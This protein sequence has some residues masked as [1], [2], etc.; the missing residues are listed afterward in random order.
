MKKLYSFVLGLLTMAAISCIA[1]ANVQADSSLSEL[2]VKERNSAG[3]TNDLVLSPSFSPEITEYNVTAMS[4]TIALDIVASVTEAG[5][6][7]DTDWLALDPGDNTSYIYVTDAE[8]NKT[9]YTI[10][11]KKLT[12]E[13]QETYV[14]E[15]TSENG[16]DA[17]EVATTEVDGF[18][19][20]ITG[21]F[22]EADIPEGFEETT[23]DFNGITVPAIKGVTKDLIAM[24]LEPVAEGTSD[25]ISGEET[26]N[27][28]I[29]G[30]T[31]EDAS[32]SDETVEMPKAGFYILRVK[33]G[34]FYEM[35]NVYIKSRMYTVINKAKTDK[36]LKP[37]D[38]ATVTIGDTEFEAWVLD[39]ENQLYLVYAM[40]WNG[41]VNLYCYDD[42]EKCFQRYIVA[43]AADTLLQQANKKLTELQTDYNNL[44]QKYN[45]TNS[46][47]W[48]IIGGLGVLLVILVFVCL[49]LALSLSRNKIM[50]E[51][52][53][54]DYLPEFENNKKAKQ[55]QEE[56]AK[57]AT[58]KKQNYY[59][60]DGDDEE[61][62]DDDELF[63]L[64][65]EEEDDDDDF[66]IYDRG[67]SIVKPV[68]PVVENRTT[69]VKPV[70]ENR[71][72]AQPEARA[73]RVKDAD[74]NKKMETAPFDIDL[75]EI[76]ISDQIKKEFESMNKSESTPEEDD[77]GFTFI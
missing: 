42:V 34:T 25:D 45:K 26:T 27:G 71:T 75:G 2:T 9:T 52:D 64:V 29:S 55:N 77:D 10:Y 20:I 24:W 30:D 15:T 11:T 61:E 4:D 35:Q 14:P 48:K 46:F 47:K 41:E 60:S 13:E 66:V 68:K 17:E 67:D 37:Y 63:T 22:T 50:K 49:N 70:V 58:R 7:Y 31:S 1:P 65:D 28:D 62:D 40:N 76:D 18:T 5:A 36:F 51:D 32:D 72:Q 73:T 39:E 8:G 33:K 12:A 23:Y 53:D 38:K 56:K 44:A 69:P 16:S 6:V 43:S 57:K 3:E 19:M 21:N 59:Y 54:E 74:A